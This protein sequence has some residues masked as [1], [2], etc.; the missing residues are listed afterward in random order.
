MIR[1]V[2]CLASATHRL[3][4][5]LPT[6]LAFAG[7]AAGAFEVALK[8]PVLTLAVPALPAMTLDIQASPP[9]GATLAMAGSGA[10]YSVTLRLTPSPA[11]ASPRT[12]AG[13]FLRALVA[14]PGMPSRDNIYRAPLDEA[15]FLVIYRL[16]DEPARM[17]HAHLLS[18]AAGPRCV[19]AHFARAAT[20]GEDEDNWRKTF[21]GAHFGP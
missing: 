6:L 18:S 15:T 8:E 7:H 16:G 5:L 14:R 10:G 4:F 21:A 3:P 12:C 9:A 17:L 11:D 2:A 13:S 19:E 1:S 20:A